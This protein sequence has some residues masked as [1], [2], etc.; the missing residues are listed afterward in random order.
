MSVIE[1]KNITKS[2][3][4]GMQKREI[5]HDLNLTVNKGEFVAIIGPSG[6]GKSTFLSIAGLLLSSDSGEICIAEQNLTNVTQSEWTK[7][8]LE[9]LGFIFQDH[10]LLSYMTVGDQLEEVSKLK[11]QK[12]AAKRKEEV[13][14]LLK[15]LGVEECYHLYP[16]QISGGQKQRVA[17]ARAFI[18]NPQ[19]ILADEPTASLNPEKAQ[20]I[21]QLIQR[22]VK[23]K[24]KSAIMVT[25]D[26][27]VLE[28][29]DIVYE[30]KKGSLVRL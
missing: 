8:R 11:G 9:L 17:I 2:F 15:E 3:M 21:A 1:L 18:G 12:D 14:T 22:E 29:V 6:S 4:D 27:S 30:L 13:Q 5:L 20:E 25:H 10:Q 23:E 16:N 7:K 19:L 26:R 28:Y 24:Q